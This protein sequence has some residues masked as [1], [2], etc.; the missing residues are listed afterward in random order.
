MH[1][2]V[3]PLIILLSPALGVPIRSR[4]LCVCYVVVLLY[5]DNDDRST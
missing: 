2:P 4:I 1:L 3:I 5:N